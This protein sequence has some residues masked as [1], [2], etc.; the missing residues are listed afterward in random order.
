[1]AID[2]NSSKIKNKYKILETNSKI[3]DVKIGRAFYILWDT[4]SDICLLLW[5]KKSVNNYLELFERFRIVVNSLKID[6]TPWL[7]IFIFHFPF[8]INLYGEIF[9]A[10]GHGFE[11][12]HRILRRHLRNTCQSTG[13]GFAQPLKLD[14][15][16]FNLVYKKIKYKRPHV[17][18]TRKALYFYQK[19]YH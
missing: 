12:R 17:S 2:V 18:R 5:K 7:H 4:F 8:F 13:D 16:R 14:N 6:V 9:L 1:M 19:I 3:M 15:I 11:G 10:I